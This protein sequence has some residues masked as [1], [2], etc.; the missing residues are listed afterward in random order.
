MQNHFAFVQNTLSKG[1]GEDRG[2]FSGQ[3][4]RTRSGHIKR[5]VLW[6][7]RLLSPSDPTE[8]EAL[9][10]AATFHDVGY[11]RN[12][13][14]HA[15]HSVDILREYAA[16]TQL[17]AAVVERATFLVA[18]HSNKAH[19]MGRKSAPRDLIA[20]MEADLLDEEGAMGLVRDIL[21]V[22]A[23]GGGY[24]EAHARMMMFEPSRI[25]RNPMVTPLAQKYWEGKQAL[26]RQFIRL[27]TYDMGYPPVSITKTDD[28]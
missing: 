12:P 3:Q 23:N 17:D 21:T 19:W 6:T 11:V 8:K 4:F 24:E 13:V 28:A 26:L 7:E 9:L 20:L 1:Q 25:A 15:K 14:H 2:E 10:L 18:E 22:G 27:Y 5:V 16:Q